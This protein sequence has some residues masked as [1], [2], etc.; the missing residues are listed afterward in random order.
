MEL[1]WVKAAEAMSAV[2]KL[3]I[4]LCREEIGGFP[5]GEEIGV[6]PKFIA[7]FE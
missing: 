4:F 6:F 5:G 2:K 3:V 7:T 1:A